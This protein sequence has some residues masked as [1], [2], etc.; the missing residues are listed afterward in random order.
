MSDGIYPCD[1]V[2]GIAGAGR[3]CFR[4]DPEQYSPLDHAVGLGCI[5]LIVG[6]VLI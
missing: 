5:A 2:F 1:P 6:A 4:E 3:Y